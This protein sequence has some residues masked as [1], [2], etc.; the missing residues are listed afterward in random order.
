[1]KSNSVSA[2]ISTPL[3]S[4]ISQ[5][6]RIGSLDVLRGLAILGILVVNIQ[7]YSMISAAYFN[8]TAYGNLEGAN[9]WVWFLTH[10][11]AD[12][13]FL[14]L[15]SMLFGAGIVLMWQRAEERGSSVFWIHYRRM[16]WLALFGL[17]HA[18]LIWYGDI[19]FAYAICGMVL[20][21]AR[22]LKPGTLL[23]LGSILLLIGFSIYLLAGTSM[24]RWPA[25]AQREFSENMWNPS[26]ESISE[27]VATYQGSWQ[28]QMSRRTAEAIGI[29]TQALL[30]FFVWR[31]GGL[32]LIGMGLY[33]LGVFSAL[34]SPRF[35]TALVG[36]AFLVG[37]PLILYGI[38]RNFESGW[39]PDRFFLGQLYNYWGSVIVSL[40]WVGL[41]VR[42]YKAG[43]L[44][45]L[46]DRLAAA[47]R[48]ALSNYLL[49]SFICTLIFYGHGL[50][51][52][53]QVSRSGQ[54]LIVFAIWAI[55]LTL[56]PLW[57][58]SFRY[59]PFEWLWRSLT[60]WTVLPIRR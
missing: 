33:K 42:I 14:T 2:P 34:R 3:L 24:S 5:A 56:S 28:T 21:W 51:M 32:M 19:L 50:G 60:Y 25:E 59:G 8:P 13:K 26:E 37:I 7:S 36:L 20:Y 9:Y 17:M 1:M 52:F 22:K 23:V 27:E 15:F 41:L 4:P 45:G 54:I 18:H 6:E 40:G 57:L 12:M 48:M 58:R 10:L 47:G 49:E 43:V 38:H 44:S 16:F 35:Y 30:F 53:G 55:I 11:L 46:I 39:P 29:E 31:A